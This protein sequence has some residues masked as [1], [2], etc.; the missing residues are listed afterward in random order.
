MPG[1][2]DRAGIRRFGGRET[3]GGAGADHPELT[4]GTANSDSIGLGRSI[5]GGL[6]NCAAAHLPAFFAPPP[7]VSPGQEGMGLAGGN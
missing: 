5:S 1:A 7:P 6:S 3:K 4:C 2:S